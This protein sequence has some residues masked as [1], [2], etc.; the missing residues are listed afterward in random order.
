MQIE[1]APITD[2]LR[3][4]EVSWKFDIPTIYNFAVIYREICYFLKSSLLFSSFYCLF[5]L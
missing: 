5:C 2:C 4:S 3:V 1:E